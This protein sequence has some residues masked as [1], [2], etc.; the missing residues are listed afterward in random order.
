MYTSRVLPN[1]NRAFGGGR[2]AAVHAQGSKQRGQVDFDCSLTEPQF[3]RYFLVRIA[4]N[5]ER[6]NVFLPGSKRRGHLW[7]RGSDF[8]GRTS[9]AGS[10]NRSRDVNDALEDLGQ[11]GREFL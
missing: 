10:R 11:S 5:N 6:E 7:F 9:G 1:K 3:S 4:F 8:V 2:G